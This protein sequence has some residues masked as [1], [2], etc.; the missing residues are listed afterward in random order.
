V[1]TYNL[2]VAFVIS[3]VTA[4]L[5][6]EAVLEVERKLSLTGAWTVALWTG[7]SKSAGLSVVIELSLTWEDALAADALEVISLE[8]SV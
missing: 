4:F 3:T 2:V 8:M 5:A 1:I 7:Y 6:E